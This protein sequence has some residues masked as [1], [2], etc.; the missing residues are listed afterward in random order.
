MLINNTRDN[1]LNKGKSKIT[2]D[3][4]LFFRLSIS[5]FAFIHFLSIQP[6]FDILYSFDSYVYP[7]VMAASN[8]KYGI[9]FLDLKNAFNGF[10]IPIAYDSLI[11][12]SRFAYPFFLLCLFIG[13]F[14]RFAAVLSLFFQV[15]F[16][17]S[18][19]MFDYGVDYFTTFSLFYCCIFPVGRIW[20]IDNK[21]LKKTESEFCNQE[22]LF[23]LRGHLGVAYFFSGFSKVIGETWR[24]GEAIW[25]TFHSHQYYYT[26][27]FDFLAD[28]NFFLILGWLT[29][30]LELL[31]PV[32]INLN[33]TR[34]F[35]LLGILL[36][37]ISI[38]LIMG[39]FFFSAL[40]II[41]NLSAY[42]APYI[43][44]NK[45]LRKVNLVFRPDVI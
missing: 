8:K 2:T 10:N 44:L 41:L 6:D 24:N 19:H 40:L 33:S 3:W 17:Q 21:I 25:K 26:L 7:D 12:F 22:Y 18:I 42:F 13:C 35:W 1:K 39:L 32:F 29:I 31:Y 38:G 43:K 4:L 45:Y 15:L 9:T 27:N 34:K 36:L 30:V 28:T 20:S 37:H 23:L 16:I 14:T 11:T 5:F